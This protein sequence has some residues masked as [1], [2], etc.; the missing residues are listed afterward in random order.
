M[1]GK[2][3]DPQ[4]E[5]NQK[6]YAQRVV[7]TL[8]VIWIAKPCPLVAAQS[9]FWTNLKLAQAITASLKGT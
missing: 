6:S 7:Q 1:S 5:A 4:Q 3:N 8:R 2:A 9:E